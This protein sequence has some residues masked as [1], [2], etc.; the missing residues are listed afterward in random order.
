MNETIEHKAQ[1][2][3]GLV[4]KHVQN[5][6]ILGVSV[7]II[8]ILWL[9]GG[10][11]K[12]PTRQPPSTSNNLDFAR[13]N[14]AK[15]EEYKKQLAA[16]ERLLREQQS[17]PQIQQSPT[18]Q[19]PSFST[20]PVGG[21][22]SPQI[23]AD[24]RETLKTQ[25]QLDQL[26]KQHESLYSSN[27]ALTYRKGEKAPND[28][29]TFK[30]FL[31][32][33]A[34]QNSAASSAQP[35]DTIKQTEAIRRAALA[36]LTA[37]PS[38]PEG[39]SPEQPRVPL[40]ESSPQSAV[41][42]NNDSKSSK[43]YNKATGNP[44]RILEGTVLETVLLNRINSDFT[45]PVNC[46]LTNPVYSHDRQRILIPE[47]SKLLGEAARVTNVGQKRV[48]VAFHRLV[49]PDGYSVSLDQF[50]GLNQIGETGLRDK[51]NNH[52]FQIFGL[53][54]ALGLVSGFSNRGVA[55]YGPGVSAGDIYRTGVSVRLAQSS[56]RLLDRYLNVLPT[57]TIRE[58]HRV[59]V[60]LSGDLEL[61]DYANHRMPAD[62]S[63][64]EPAVPKQETK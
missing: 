57:V 58:G 44:Y 5:Y 16:Q 6:L 20:G 24:P 15:L 59:K 55:Y 42:K 50:K 40:R 54:I 46:M 61:P 13:L 30:E 43:D 11:Q 21:Q 14:E 4:P 19:D 17:L 29:E 64:A 33:L 7:V 39:P 63:T 1:K 53:S 35:P 18:S 34:P 49:M 60:Y 51:V 62:L 28:L 12:R 22:S 25:L 8:V 41:Q 23:P 2:P 56:H 3:P 31:K 52:Y 9:T 37:Q 10:D 27:I 32:T 36:T 26:K 48:A 38:K 45:G 47:G